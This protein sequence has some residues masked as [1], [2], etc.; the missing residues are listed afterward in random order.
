M[1]KFS[2]L[3]N[4]KNSFKYE[5]GCVMLD[6]NVKNWNKIITDIIDKDDIYDEEGYGLE[7]EPHI[8]L[9][10]GYGDD[11]QDKDIKEICEKYIKPTII[12]SKISIFENDDFDV[13][14]FDIENDLV[15]QINKDLSI[16][17]HTST[18]PDYQPHATISYIKKGKGK[19][20]IQELKENI[21][22][23]SDKII[24]SKPTGTSKKNKITILKW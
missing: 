6:L 13:V 2:K 21:K 17:P 7:T 5:Y 15:I 18:F 4:E 24:Y 8:T 1:K 23:E 9:L 19:K 10:F 16:L 11:V 3:I 20:Y 14:K 22:I 12:L